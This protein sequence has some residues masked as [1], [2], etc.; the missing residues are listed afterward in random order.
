MDNK[1]KKIN[2][3][4]AFIGLF[5]LLLVVFLTLLRPALQKK[6]AP[7][8]EAQDSQDPQEQTAA[9]ITCKELFQKLSAGEPLNIFDIR[10][11][12][13]FQAEHLKNSLNV[14]AENIARLLEKDK[15]YIILDDGNSGLARNLAANLKKGS[16][17]NVFYLDGGF[18][19]WRDSYFPTI[20]AGNQNSIV[21]QAKVSFISPDDLKNAMQDINEKLIIIDVRNSDIFSFE[22]LKDSINITLSNIESSAIKI[23]LGGKAIVYDNN[24]ELSFRAAVKLFDLRIFPVY[25]LS[26]GLDAW[27]QKG[28]EIIK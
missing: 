21:D 14:P 27:K 17:S 28:Y 1:R 10:S 5:L 2:T 16:V 9:K 3:L 23:P 22:H 11:E 7:S 6:A 4:V 19:A 24:E 15:F 12:E 20:S 26:G 25:I 18:Q 13:E 8:N